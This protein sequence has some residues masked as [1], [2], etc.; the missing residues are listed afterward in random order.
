[1]NMTLDFVDTARA[2]ASAKGNFHA[3]ASFARQARMP[4]RVIATLSKAAVSGS[5][6]SGLTGGSDYDAT[7]SELLHA[8]RSRSAFDAMFAN[9]LTPLN[10]RLLIA[11]AISGGLVAE[12]AAVKVGGTISVTGAGLVPLKVQALVATTAESWALPTAAPLIQGALLNALASATDSVFLSAIAALVVGAATASAGTSPANVQT[13]LKTL[14]DI[15]STTG[16]GRP[17]LVVLPTAANSLSTMNVGGQPA[18]PDMT[19]LGGTVAGV[20]VLVTTELAAATALLLDADGISAGTGN[21]N[22]ST[23]THGTLEMSDAPANDST[24]PAA[25]ELV[26]MWQ[27]NTVA[28]LIGRDIGFEMQRVTAAALLTGGW[29]A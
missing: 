29:T 21:V 2:L 1:M 16:A 14:L 3:A 12:G 28:A 18:F 6:I 13:D 17:F 7:V 22:L 23:S 4:G 10:T 24:T 15:V 19:P 8:L 11:T 26:S 9:S 5:D 20:P 25:A 27:T